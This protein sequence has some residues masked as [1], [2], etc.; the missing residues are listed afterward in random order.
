MASKKNAKPAT[1]VLVTNQKG[2]SGKTTTAMNLAAA[3]HD[4]GK[5]VLLVDYDPQN[6]LLG[7]YGQADEAA[8]IQVPYLNLA[9]PGI[10]ISDELESRQFDFDYIVIDGRPTLEISMSALLLLSDLVLVPLQASLADLHSTQGI[11]KEIRA[12]QDDR[13]ELKFALVLTMVASKRLQLQF[14]K[15]AIK[16]LGYPLCK[17][18]IA[19][20]ELHTH[21][22]ALG[23]TVFA[24]NAVG[25]RAAA[26]EARKLAAE[27][28]KLVS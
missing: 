13:P 16:E 18:M 8:P 3:Y 5:R 22:Y 6:T 24:S 14:T 19:R 20:R 28:E 1:I 21:A 9:H 11:V 17:T 4:Q 23:Q 2:G 15:D 25:Y 26:D 10:D 27:V 7:W 12:A